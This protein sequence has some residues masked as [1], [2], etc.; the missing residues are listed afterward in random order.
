MFV[1]IGARV[2]PE[3]AYG[4]DIETEHETARNAGIFRQLKMSPR[5][6]P[7]GP[8]TRANG[9]RAVRGRFFRYSNEGDRT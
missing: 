3:R 5:E 1:L 4:I 9:N 8:L 7:I 2:D 6:R